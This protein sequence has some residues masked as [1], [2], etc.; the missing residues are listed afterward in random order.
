M[1]NLNS[2]LLIRNGEDTDFTGEGLKHLNYLKKLR[3]L[4]LDGSEVTDDSLAHLRE[5]ELEY[6]SLWRCTQVTEAGLVL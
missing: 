1:T 5:L 2:L 4:K 3:R 6:L